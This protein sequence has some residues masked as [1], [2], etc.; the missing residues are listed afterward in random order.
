MTKWSVGTLLAVLGLAIALVSAPAGVAK[1]REDVRVR[2]TCT[3]NS[4]SKLKLS[5]EDGRIEVE[6]EVDQNRSGVRWNVALFQNG[7]RIARLTRVTRAPSG[8]FEARV[9]APNRAGTDRFVARA[10]RASGET[11]SARASF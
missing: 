11:C 6:F 8:S 9:V 4:T 7:K 2:G 5:D 1:D 3:A 10:T